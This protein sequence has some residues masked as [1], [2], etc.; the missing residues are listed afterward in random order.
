MLDVVLMVVDEMVAVVYN[1][2]VN[3]MVLS[4]VKQQNVL[5]FSRA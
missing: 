4:R 5:F 3:E 2:A 1:A